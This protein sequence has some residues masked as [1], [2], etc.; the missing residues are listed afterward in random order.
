MTITSKKFP[1][2]INEKIVK[3]ISY[4]KNEPLW[5]TNFRLNAYKIFKNKKNPKWGADLSKINFN[6]LRYYL[7]PTESI[8]DNWEKL[9]KKI[10]DTYKKLKIPE[11]EKNYL[12][13]LNAQYESEAVYKRVNK[14]LQKK[15]IIFC[16]IDTAL[17]KYPHMFKKYF[18]TL[19]KTDDNKYSAL[20]SA[21]WSGGTFLY[22]P[23]N[24][25]V[26]LPLQAYFRINSERFGQFERTLI[27]ANE[28][29]KVH[30][31]EGCTAPIYS[32]TSLHAAVV[33]I[34]ALKNSQI[35][36]TT[37]QNWSNN[38]YN[39]VTKRAIAYESAVVEWVDC[40]IGSRITM[41]YPCVI[42]KGNNS[43]GQVLSLAYAGSKQHHDAGAKIFHIGKNTKSRV[44][45][46]SVSKK[47][48][49]TSFRGLITIEKGSKNSLSYVSCNALMMNKESR[50]DTYPTV[51]IKEKQ[52]VSQHEATVEK[53]GEKKL[54]Y[55][56]SRGIKK[57][58]AESLLVNSFI[59]PVTKELP[60]EYSVELYRLINLEMSGTVG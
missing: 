24:T 7:K 34:F 2:G 18:A 45:S 32:S 29:S 8:F 11:I 19:V 43:K 17:K 16:D 26:E 30:Y 20:N 51:V 60:I 38:I 36:Y 48:G 22:V 13:G 12:G 15:G 59:E 25:Y 49:R 40:N 27:I 53:L 58:N 6:N 23:K 14:D 50:S 55:M 39:L 9:P 1:K 44:I 52:S 5:M 3:K 4:I 41:K 54:F 28:G 31:I 10:K 21:V 46:K 33:E 57:E 42:L 47:R 56:T 35:K 37:I